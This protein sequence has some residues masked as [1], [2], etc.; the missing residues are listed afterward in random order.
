[1]SGPSYLKLQHHR[2]QPER[3]SRFDKYDEDAE[4]FAGVGISRISSVRARSIRGSVASMICMPVSSASG[5]SKMASERSSNGNR[6][7]AA[8]GCRWS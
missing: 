7:R 3:W 6:S 1:M 5:M 2:K 4:A 8:T